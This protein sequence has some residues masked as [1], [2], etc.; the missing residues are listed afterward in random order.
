MKHECN[1]LEVYKD[2]LTQYG[3]SKQEWVLIEEIG[4]LL[5]ALSKFKRGRVKVE[6]IIT[7]LADVHVMVE[8]IA[9]FYGW[10]C[11]LEEKYAKVN[12]LKIKLK[13]AVQ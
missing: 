5:N 7:E 1:N 10:D 13:K 11:F 8:Q 2:A 9:L 12:R 6:D 3:Y 4:E